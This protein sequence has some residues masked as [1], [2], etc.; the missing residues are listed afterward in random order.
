MK[1][2]LIIIL[3][4]SRAFCQQP[5]AYLSVNSQLA[6]LP[7]Y[8]DSVRI[9]MTPLQN[10]TIQPGPHVLVVPS[11]CG[12]V[13]NESGYV[14][15]FSAEPGQRYNFEPFFTRNIFINSVPYGAHVLI[16]NKLR[17]YTP[18]MIAAVPQYIRIEKEG[19][20]PQD[21]DVTKVQGTSLT[22]ELKPLQS[23]LLANQHKRQDQEKN[24]KWRKRFMWCSMALAAA[25]GYTTIYYHNRGNDAHS[26]YLTASLPAEMNRF[27]DKAH[28][29]DNYAGW[30]YTL[31]EVGFVMTGYF[32]LGS[33]E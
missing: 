14:Q 29:Y 30:S 33:R 22:M 9:G 15:P 13:W 11:P 18:L 1:K 23:W 6:P 27:Y 16:D 24:M 7:V 3:L 26:Q 5:D 32:F 10:Y 21:I 28:R 12:L 2:C 17:G 19:Y 31:F 8:L 25:A 4:F 20:E